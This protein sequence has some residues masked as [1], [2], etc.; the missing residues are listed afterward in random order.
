VNRVEVAQT[1]PGGRTLLAVHAP[2]PA[3]DLDNTDK[4]YP[5]RRPYLHPVGFEVRPV[6][7]GVVAVC[8]LGGAEH[9]PYKNLTACKKALTTI[10]VPRATHLTGGAA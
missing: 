4:R 10:E 6:D 9:G 8:Y 5:K 7:G 1:L 2:R 3:D